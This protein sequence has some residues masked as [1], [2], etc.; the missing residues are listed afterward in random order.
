MN[1][2]VTVNDMSS[3]FEREPERVW[4]DPCKA[5][6]LSVYPEIRHARKTIRST[7]ALRGSAAG[8]VILNLDGA[9]GALLRTPPPGAPP[10]HPHH[11]WWVESGFDVLSVC[12]E[13]LG[14]RE[15]AR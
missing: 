5:R 4:P 12:G 1:T 6:G 9:P 15:N 3:H 13:V 2:P 11:T 14:V 8:V 7:P 10:N